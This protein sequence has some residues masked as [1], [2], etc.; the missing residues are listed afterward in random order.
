MKIINILLLVSV[1]IF[2]IIQ[3]R[4]SSSIIRTDWFKNLSYNE[5]LTITAEIK[6]NWKTS[7]ILL[8]II[9]CAMLI[10][11]SSFIGKTHYYENIINISI[12]IINIIVTIL[13]I[14]NNQKLS[15]DIKK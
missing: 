8:A 2:G 7:I 9:V 10:L 5:K 15:K 11:I 6:D 4:K 12:L 3:M 1:F 13:L 14:V